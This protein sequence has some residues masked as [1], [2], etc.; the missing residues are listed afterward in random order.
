MKA[1]A[2]GRDVCTQDPRRMPD[3]WTMQTDNAVAASRTLAVEHPRVR[4][5]VVGPLL[6]EIPDPTQSMREKQIIH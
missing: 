1:K 5:S 4:R 3:E 6:R 2:G